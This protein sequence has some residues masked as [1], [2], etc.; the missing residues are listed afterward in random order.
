MAGA[1]TFDH[2]QASSLFDESPVYVGG[3]TVNHGGINFAKKPDLISS[4]NILLALVIAGVSIV[5]Y[6]KLGVKK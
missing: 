4:Q 1:I 2:N 3:Q 6:K 5:A